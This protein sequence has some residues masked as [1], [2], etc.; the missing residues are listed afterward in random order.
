MCSI[1]EIWNLWFCL[2]TESHSF[3][4]IL[5]DLCCYFA[6]MTGFT[7]QRLN[8]VHPQENSMCKLTLEVMFY[9]L[10]ALPAMAAPRLVNSKYIFL[11]NFPQL[12][13]KFTGTYDHLFCL[14]FVVFFSVSRFSWVSLILE[15]HPQLQWFHV[16]TG[17]V[18]QISRQN[19]A[20]LP[21]IFVLIRLSMAMEVAL[22][23]T[24]SQ[25]SCPL[26][27]LLPVPWL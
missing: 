14:S 27:L 13:F 8:L 18:T 24:I 21:T 19:R 11:C 10:A 2:L 7:T 16:Q 23:V 9:G 25:I 15:P 22:L 1:Q 20:V 26:I 6:F 5:F 17:D 4:R 3:F 12:D